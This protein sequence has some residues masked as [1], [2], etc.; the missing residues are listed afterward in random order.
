VY[1]VDRL[2]LFLNLDTTQSGALLTVT[3]VHYYDRSSHPNLVAGIA[4]VAVK[5]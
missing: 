2:I 4:E 3:S 5:A 1:L